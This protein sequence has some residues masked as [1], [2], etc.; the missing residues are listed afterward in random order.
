MPTLSPDNQRPDIQGFGSGGLPPIRPPRHTYKSARYRRRRATAVIA[1]LALVAMGAAAV[2]SSWT[3]DRSAKR[4]DK[5]VAAKP[6]PPKPPSARPIRAAEPGIAKVIFD[7]PK[8][9]EVA[10]TFDDGFCV[11]C[12]KK[13]VRILDKTGAHAT[14]FPNGVYGPATWDLER[15]TI[16]RMVEEGR[17]VIGN[18]SFMHYNAA[19]LSKESVQMELA[20]N[21]AWIQKT[22]NT[23]SRPYYRPPFGNHN[24]LVR[25]TAGELGYTKIMMWSGEV[26]DRTGTTVAG[27]VREFKRWAKPGIIVLL[28]A[29][30]QSTADAL[31]G[32]LEVL[33]R[34][35]LKPVTLDEI[36]RP[37]PNQ[38]PAE[39]TNPQG[40][41]SSGDA[42]KPTSSPRMSQ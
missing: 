33:K 14:F 31:P 42:A 25:A 6:K 10:L 9:R 7:A 5:K 24:S 36:L 2:F 34:R 3:N 28:H 22:F 19:R 32:M 26:H 12:V 20:R 15:H 37:V 38:P 29:N 13:I 16:S 8:R 18:H 41:S 11:K 17:L 30:R 40:P 1:I 27:A 23:T 21:E 35:N 39:G 4:L